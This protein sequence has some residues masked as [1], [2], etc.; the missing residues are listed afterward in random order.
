MPNAPALSLASKVVRDA[1]VVEAEIDNEVV[2]INIE[3]GNCYGLNAV[4]SRVWNLIATPVSIGEVCATL[5]GEYD[6]QPSACEE[7]VLNLL[8]ELR[9]EGLISTLS[10]K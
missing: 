1:D 5:T 8:E 3:T 7:Q 10:D 2:A 6:V 9:A 4:G